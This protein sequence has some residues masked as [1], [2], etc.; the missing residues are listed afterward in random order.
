M[1]ALEGGK[2]GE[3]GIELSRLSTT[4]G[5]SVVMNRR[6]KYERG[7][8]GSLCFLNVLPDILFLCDIKIK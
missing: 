4:Y 8:N 2:G 6:S 7:K 5:I 3:G 1:T